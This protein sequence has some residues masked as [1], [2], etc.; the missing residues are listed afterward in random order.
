MQQV[1]HGAH[2]LNRAIDNRTGLDPCL[3]LWLSRLLQEHLVQ[4]HL[5]HGQFLSQSVV[6]IACD[7]TP[8]LVL[9]SHEAN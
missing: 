2:F 4:Y 8:F 9:H 5:R 1:R 3:L 6:Q 7:A